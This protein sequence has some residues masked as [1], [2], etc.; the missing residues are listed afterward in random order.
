MYFPELQKRENIELITLNQL[1]G[2]TS[3]FGFDFYPRP[4]SQEDL[5]KSFKEF[6]PISKPRSEYHY[7]NAG[8][9]IV[10]YALENAY[11]KNYSEILED[12]LL[13]PLGM[14]STFLNVPIE[15]EK[16]IA[17]GHNSKNEIE[18]YQRDLPFWFAAAS[19]KST[20]EDIAKYLNAHISP[21]LFG[22]N[23]QKAISIV[24]QNKY[25]FVDELS[26]EQLAW[27]AHKISELNKSNPDSLF[28][29]FEDGKPVF[30]E[31]KIIE[32]K[33]FNNQKI[34]ID[35]TGSGYGMSGYM[36]YLPEQKKGIV[37]LINKDIGNQRVQLGREILKNL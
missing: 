36:A 21:E 2:H 17:L 15:R 19:L 34:F 10:G 5:K 26:C 12:S 13:N 35:K 9:G 37:I 4:Q 31:M 7:S 25:C 18:T 28:I 6:V 22:L 20:I 23:F 30:E 27:Q 14:K 16:L 33:S 3:G 8:I 11:S 1:L 32:N 24:H 29:R